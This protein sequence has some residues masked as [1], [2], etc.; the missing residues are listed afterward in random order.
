MP[1]KIKQSEPKPDIVS[2]I[3]DPHS[4]DKYLEDHKKKL[5]RL[6]RELTG[7]NMEEPWGTY[8]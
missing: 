4:Y 7:E 3:K 1:K 8:D 5:K 2:A 6:E